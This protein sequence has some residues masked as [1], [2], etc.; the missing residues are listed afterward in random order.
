MRTRA[1]EQ[2]GKR[3]NNVPAEPYP[4]VQRQEDG[5]A[6]DVPVDDALRV[7]VGQRL[8]HRLAHRRY[9]LFVQPESKD[10]ESHGGAVRGWGGSRPR[11][12][13]LAR[14]RLGVRR[15]TEVLVPHNRY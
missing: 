13:S 5:V 1:C 4:P 6:L 9:L 11:V 2:E 8:Q 10:T 15:Q 7:K 12:S 3:G 14:R